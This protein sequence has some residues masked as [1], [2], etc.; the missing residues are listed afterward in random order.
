[1]ATAVQVRNN[2][3][4]GDIQYDPNFVELN[5]NPQEYHTISSLT[6]VCK[7]VTLK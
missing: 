3:L 5:V 6:R 4:N 7:L 1:M 2:T